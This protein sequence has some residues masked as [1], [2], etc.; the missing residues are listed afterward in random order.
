[1]EVDVAAA[2]AL[3]HLRVTSDCHPSEGRGV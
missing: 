2:D 1:V 3:G